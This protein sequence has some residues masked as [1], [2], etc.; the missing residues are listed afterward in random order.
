MDFPRPAL[1]DVPGLPR[2]PDDFRAPITSDV[3]ALLV[4]GTFDGRTPPPNAEVVARGLPDAR[5]LV[6]DGA[7]HG[8]FGERAVL[9]AML[10]FFRE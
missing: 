4:S 6:I 5:L 7:S 9:E 1:C 10:A 3:R 8:L 2:L